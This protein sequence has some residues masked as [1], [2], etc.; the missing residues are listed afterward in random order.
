MKFLHWGW[1]NT[2]T[3]FPERW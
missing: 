2:G 3:S 1:W